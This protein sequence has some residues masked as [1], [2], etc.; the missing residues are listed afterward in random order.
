MK[1][2][3][4]VDDHV[5]IR[6]GLKLILSNGLFDTIDE[7][8]NGKD[9]LNKMSLN[10]YDLIITDINMPIMNGVELV[11]EIRKSDS[12]QKILV[13][14]MHLDVTYIDAMLRLQVNGYLS[15]SNPSSELLDAIIAIDNGSSY[16]SRDASNLIMERLAG[17]K[18][19][20]PVLST[21]EIS[22]LKLIGEEKTV[23]EIS[24]IMNLS[25]RTVETIRARL[26]AKLNAKN[27]A[28]LVLYGVKNN[29]II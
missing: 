20:V 16:F 4:L 17:N 5:L 21:S 18:N 29:I 12:Y 3:L 2:L 1:K 28:G 9:A 22:I 8:K 13:L 15:K 23:R 19:E 10:N 24:E 14:T 26:L 7:A 27:T 25:A 6:E 11:T